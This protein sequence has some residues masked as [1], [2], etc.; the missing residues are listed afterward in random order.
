MF[1]FDKEAKDKG[2]V[3]LKEFKAKFLWI[4]MS[5][6]LLGNHNKAKRT[7]GPDW[8]DFS[9]TKGLSH[10]VSWSLPNWITK[11]KIRDNETMKERNCI[12]VTRFSANSYRLLKREWF[13][14]WSSC[15]GDLEEKMILRKKEK[16]IVIW[17][18][19]EWK[20]DRLQDSDSL[21]ISNDW[22]D[23]STEQICIEATEKII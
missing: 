15:E 3:P 2:M 20:R 9:L 21:A 23:R 17:R 14:W 11:G 1:N 16:Q 22:G 6:S 7:T 18:H 5:L 10:S 19:Y 4:W 8:R 13:R 12:V